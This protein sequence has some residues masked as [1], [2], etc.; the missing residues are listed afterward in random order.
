MSSVI[1]ESSLPLFWGRSPAGVLATRFVRG[2]KVCLTSP[3]FLK[4]YRGYKGTYATTS[5]TPNPELQPSSP[6][7]KR[8]HEAPEAQHHAKP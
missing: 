2:R 6:F 4:V 7:H 8:L 5:N 1:P 3:S